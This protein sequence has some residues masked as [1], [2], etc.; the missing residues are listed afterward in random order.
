MC[1]HG[2]TLRLAFRQKTTYRS[3]TTRRARSL[4][5]LEWL[6]NIG[7]VMSCS[8][9][10]TLPVLILVFPVRNQC[11]RPTWR[12][13]LLFWLPRRSARV[14]G[15]LA[16]GILGL[17]TRTFDFRHGLSVNA[18]TVAFV[19][20]HGDLLDLSADT[21]QCSTRTSATRS[22]AA[23]GI[24]R[25]RRWRVATGPL[26]SVT[27]DGHE[28]SG[29]GLATDRG[30]RG[31]FRLR[32]QHGVAGPASSTPRLPGACPTRGVG[33]RVNLSLTPVMVLGLVSGG[34]RGGRRRGDF[35]VALRH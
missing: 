23:R 6:T 18:V 25:G 35:L 15:V 19:T 28:C 5:R 3:P 17:L 34:P 27:H 21:S 9:P 14:L 4:R 10:V 29:R 11:V 7:D 33:P 22:A 31:A 20:E 1:G 24:L 8:H 26:V 16:R 30:V 13:Y 32:E 2:R 12:Y